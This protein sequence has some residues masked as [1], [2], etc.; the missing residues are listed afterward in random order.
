MTD[1]PPEHPGDDLPGAPLEDNPRV[2]VV[3][4]RDEMQQSYID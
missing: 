1:L 3:E 4:L 2:R